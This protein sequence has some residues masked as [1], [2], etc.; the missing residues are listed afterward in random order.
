MIGP[1]RCA[2]LLLGPLLLLVSGCTDPQL[3]DPEVPEGAEEAPPAE[4]EP[5]VDR[6][7]LE[8]QIDRFAAVIADVRDALAPA[9]DSD[10]LAEIQ[11]AA[12]AAYGSMV[13]EEDG[14]GLFPS[15]IGEQE[16]DSAGEDVLTETLAIARDRGGELGRATVEMLRDPVAGDIGAWERDPAGMLAATLATV[17]DVDDLDDGIAAVSELDGDGA[18]AIAWLALARDTDDATLAAGA[19]ERADGHLGV[20]DVAL[21]LLQEEQ[22]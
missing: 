11:R 7:Q 21:E 12:D 17:E 8:E 19:V 4:E 5:D 22:V 2:A 10:D 18:R 1:H 16:R 6:E 3:A 15:D 20:I 14:Q 13:A 9:L